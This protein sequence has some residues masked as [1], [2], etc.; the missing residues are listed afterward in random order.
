VAASALLIGLCSSCTDPT[1]PL[2]GAHDSSTTTSLPATDVPD[3]G[4]GRPGSDPDTTGWAQS[5]LDDT[6]AYARSVDSTG[7]VIIED[8]HIVAEQYWPLA[9]DLGGEA[10]RYAE[11]SHLGQT[12]D[13]QPI[14]DVASIQK[15][16]T[17]VLVGI[18]VDHGEIDPDRPV[19]DYL[20]SGWSHATTD[21]ELAITVSHLLTMSSGLDDD[22]RFEAPAGRRWRY[23][24]NAYSQLLPVLTA[25][26]GLP[27]DT[28]TTDRL[29]SPLG[30]AHSH[31]QNR[32]GNLNLSS[33]PWG[34]TTTPH[35]LAR[36][37]QLILN[38]GTWNDSPIV[39]A[40]W[41]DISTAT[42]QSPNPAYGYL[43]W[44]NNTE[45]HLSAPD[46]ATTPSGP[47]NPEAPPDTITA[48]GHYQRR[49]YLIPT[50]NIIV[51][52]FGAPTPHFD[53]ELWRRLSPALPQ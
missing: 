50:R 49:L 25:A 17:S 47:L 38:R 14:E 52:R 33:N 22:L 46:G 20:G 1:V 40:D 32:P 53:E 29:T 18:A 2:L 8:G 27:L 42:N 35:D 21:Q 37:G 41:I 7:L 23:N 44:L 26:T 6:F 3:P 43:W 9:E 48:M 13:G 28:L 4:W 12:D 34:F 45:S 31:W 36:F 5:A 10:A 51:V 11:F 24:T 19:T 15:S 39:S 16:I 30:M